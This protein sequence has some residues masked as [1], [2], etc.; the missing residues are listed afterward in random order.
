MLGAAGPDAYL[1]NLRPVGGLPGPDGGPG[2]VPA[3]DP[4]PVPGPVADWLRAPAATRLVGPAYD[5][6]RDAGHRLSGGSLGGWF[7]ALV[8]VREVGPSRPLDAAADRG[9]PMRGAGRCAG[10]GA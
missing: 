1:L 4:D 8:H 5:A 3:S 9:G 6:A 2:P 7:D 10:R